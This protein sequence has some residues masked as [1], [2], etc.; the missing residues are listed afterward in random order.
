MDNQWL[1]PQ[2]ELQRPNPNTETTWE[3][4]GRPGPFPFLDVCLL[5]GCIGGVLTLQ[6][7]LCDAKKAQKLLV[8]W[9][10]THRQLWSLEKMRVR[11][12]LSPPWSSKHAYEL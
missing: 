9:R 12:A 5:L 10:F 11:I 6:T 4:S 2:T 3:G 8:L 1:L 7:A